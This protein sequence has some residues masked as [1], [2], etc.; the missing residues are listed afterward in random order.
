MSYVRR[1][2][3]DNAINEIPTRA[4]P[5]YCMDSPQRVPS[6]DD[7]AKARA[8]L[9]S[10]DAV[11][12]AE[13]YMEVDRPVGTHEVG[14]RPPSPP[15]GVKQTVSFNRDASRVPSSSG[16]DASADGSGVGDTSRPR[17]RVNS[18]EV[19]DPL[20]L[21]AVLRAAVEAT[22]EGNEDGGRE[23]LCEL[24]LVPRPVESVTEVRARMSG[25]SQLSLV[26]IVANVFAADGTPVIVCEPSTPGVQPARLR[27]VASVLEVGDTS[28]AG[29]VPSSPAAERAQQ[30]RI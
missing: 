24:M 22:S 3:L 19:D 2:K 26:P 15:R 25:P 16:H 8:L 18:R 1:E 11:A 27:A 6:Y 29:G 7:E 9:L 17:S 4:P 30:M 10:A 12:D 28:P 5:I 21:A 23:L 14:I 13:E 20:S